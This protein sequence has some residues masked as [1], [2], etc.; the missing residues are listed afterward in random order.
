MLRA[1]NPFSD[2]VK[3]SLEPIFATR[4]PKTDIQAQGIPSIGLGPPGDH[5]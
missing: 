1:G 5:I 3:T 2:V 4:R